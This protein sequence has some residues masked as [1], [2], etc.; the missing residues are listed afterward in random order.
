MIRSFAFN[1]LDVSSLAVLDRFFYKGDSLIEKKKILASQNT[2]N[3][4]F[5]G[6]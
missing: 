2:I 1:F 5:Y 6:Q 3:D 4:I